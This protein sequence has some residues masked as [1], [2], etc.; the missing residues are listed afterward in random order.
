MKELENI[1]DSL[2]ELKHDSTI[3]KNIREKIEEIITV[4]NDGSDSSIKI[5]KALDT[6]DEIADD[7]NLEPYIRTQI[8]NVVSLLEKL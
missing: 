6:L 8:W 2:T 7:A 4:L 3:P 1:N 5:N